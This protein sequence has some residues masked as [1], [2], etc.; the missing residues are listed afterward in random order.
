MLHIFAVQRSAARIQG[1]SAVFAYYPDRAWLQQ[2]QF[3][4]CDARY[5]QR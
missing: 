3:L 1:G 2:S 4:N 5:V